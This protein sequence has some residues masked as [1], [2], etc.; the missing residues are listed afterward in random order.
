MRQGPL[1][2]SWNWQFSRNQRGLD[3]AALV[4]A[5][6]HSHADALQAAYEVRTPIEVVPNAT[7]G[8][9]SRQKKEPF[10]FSAGRWWDEAKNGALVDA[11]AQMIR[12]P[13]VMA[14]SLEGPNGQRFQPAHAVAV[15]SL[16]ALE[17]RQMMTKAMIFIGPS[18]YEPFGLAVL[19][20]AS[21]GS[22]LVLSD[23]PTFREL[24]QDVALFCPPD[25]KAAFATA[26]DR[27]MADRCLCLR[28]SEGAR[29]RAS[30]FSSDRQVEQLLQAYSKILSKGAAAP[31]YAA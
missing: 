19:E 9:P 30:W 3:S 26:I 22:A 7:L 25:D 2:E 10:V 24:W 27:V 31:A 6:S 17:V 16:T 23:I 20:A 11:V 18:R 29:R 28:L 13:V 1:P 12:C 15:G 5:P 8:G 4:L 21:A 14:G